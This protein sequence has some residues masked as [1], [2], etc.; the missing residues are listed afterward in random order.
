MA[1]PMP[2]RY[3]SVTEFQFTTDQA[4]AIIRTAAYHRKDFALSVIWFPP[5][6][7]V[8]VRQSIAAPFPRSSKTDLGSLDQL[9]L[10]LL[11][12]ILLHLDMHSLFYIRQTNLR[13]RDIVDSLKQ[14]RIVVQ[15][16]LNL[17]CALL[18]TRLAMHVSLRDAYAALCTETCSLCGE[19][20][21]FVSRVAWI[22]CCFACLQRAAPPL[23]L[24][25]RAA[26]RKQFRLTK[27]E[28]EGLRSLRSLPGV[29][30]LAESVLKTRVTLVSTHHAHLSSTHTHTQ[31]QHP[32]H[33]LPHA[34]PHTPKYTSMGSCALP[35]YNPLSATLEHGICCAGCQLAIEEDII[36]TEGEDWAY[37]ARDKV[38]TRDGFLGHFRWCEQAQLLW[39]ARCDGMEGMEGMGEMVPVMARMGGFFGRR[40]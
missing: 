33:P 14:Y 37:E 2:P 25:A 4:D 34:L 9:P 18:R 31:T 36:G 27:R 7:H 21:G 3:R 32:Q 39:R 30:T 16:G 20:A 8:A 38:Y 5:R 24:H 26:V 17:L 1:T 23:Q 6:E 40:V 19:F 10:E 15:H 29:Y 12:D 28:S 11:H 22:R 13:A 35:Y